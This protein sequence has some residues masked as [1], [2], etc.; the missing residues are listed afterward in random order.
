MKLGI[1]LLQN[2]CEVQKSHLVTESNW[3]K[4]ITLYTFGQFFSPSLQCL[5]SNNS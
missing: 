1:L 5:G 4:G 2:Y 3:Y